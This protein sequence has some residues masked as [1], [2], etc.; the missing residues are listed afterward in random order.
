MIYVET[1]REVSKRKRSSPLREGAAGLLLYIVSLQDRLDVFHIKTVVLFKL[2]CVQHVEDRK[3]GHFN[4]DGG[5]M[6]GSLLLGWD[7]QHRSKILQI[8]SFVVHGGDKQQGGPA[9]GKDGDHLRQGEG[10]TS[11]IGNDNR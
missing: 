4:R 9:L 5:K 2:A 8:V 7:I 10:G 3:N 11:A 6:D 1:G